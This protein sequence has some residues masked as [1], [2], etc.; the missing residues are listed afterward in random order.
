MAP[1]PRMPAPALEVETVGGGRWRLRDQAPD[2]FTLIVA[3]RGQH[4]PICKTYLQEL[5][6]SAGKFAERGVGVLV[7]STDDLERARAA[8]EDWQLSALTVGYGLSVDKAREWGLYISSGRGKTSAG[9]EE[10]ALFNEP[11]VYLVR[12]DGTLYASS[13]ATMPF[14]RPHFRDVLAALDVIIAKDY[15]ARGEA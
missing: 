7:V 5:N 15:P 4:C 8:R 14:A 2:H 12:P 9:I 11:G 1:K 10:P 3:Y 6:R 13:I